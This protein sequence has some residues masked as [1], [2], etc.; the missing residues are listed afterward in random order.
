MDNPKIPSF[1][2][3]LGFLLGDGSIF[4]KIRLTSSGSFLFIP[5]LVFPQKPSEY[6]RHMYT[7]MSKFFENLGV[8]CYV[9]T[10]KGESASLYIEGLKAV[11]PLVFLFKEYKGLGYWKSKN[12]DLLIEFLKYH[13]AGVQTFKSGLI[14]L[15]NVLYKYPNDREKSLDEW[16]SLANDYFKNVEEGYI[17][18]NH[19]IQPL[20]GR[21]AKA[22]EF[23]AWR[24]VFPEKV[25]SYKNLPI[26]QFSF[27]TY[28]SSSKALEAAIEY[29]DQVLESI[30]KELATE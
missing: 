8:K 1:P 20:K 27:S 18:G 6:N 21:G 17:S 3:L 12:I 16:V 24:A 13:S 29:R 22:N 25:N 28:G 23:I 26:K 4:V 2:Y 30:L 19:L 15:L 7:M 10:R 14:A 9:T 5:F 11:T